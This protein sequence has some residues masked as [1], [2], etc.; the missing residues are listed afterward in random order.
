[1]AKKTVRDRQ[2]ALAGAS[3]EAR[4]PASKPWE[5]PPAEIPD[6]VFAF[7]SLVAIGLFLLVTVWF[8]AGQIERQIMEST[9]AAL[10]GSGFDDV[11][12][13]VDGR[14][15]ILTG[16]VKTDGGVGLA[17]SIAAETEGVRVIKNRLV[18]V[19]PPPQEGQALFELVP[20]RLTW[21]GR[22]GEITGSVATL[23]ERQRV[24]DVLEP[25][26]A[27]LDA[28]GL[29]VDD[30]LPVT[31]WLGSFSAL[32]PLVHSATHEGSVM[33]NP[34]GGVV[35]VAGE[36]TQRRT[37]DQVLQRAEEL[38]L[39]F[40]VVNAMSLEDR[41]R[42][43]RQQVEEL[44]VDLND[45]LVNAIVEFE[46]N[47]A[48]ISAKGRE[49]LDDVGAV[50]GGHAEIPVEIA[51]H[52]DDRG[53]EEA[54]YDLALRRAE[55]V[56]AYLVGL[57]LDGGRFTVVSFGETQPVA[58]NSTEAGRQQNRRIEFTAMEE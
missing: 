24:L 2:K 4:V 29:T 37:R 5:K 46:T 7:L 49:L 15:I 13:Q 12:A 39:D 20:L 17:E 10:V 3:S 55:S 43:T 50:L 19:E 45:L 32:A 27:S 47:S 16:R 8:N 42:P 11:V 44:Q 54:N 51:G 57:G 34:Q 6:S 33:V 38:F 1:M 36:T 52:A 31:E 56:L 40:E 21:I 58:D 14:D 35:V 23:E 53:S 18:V 28:D 25:L 9:Q 26:F 48:V 22:T 41:P 30:A